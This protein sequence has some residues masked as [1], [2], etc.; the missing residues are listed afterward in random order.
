MDM[1][2]LNDLICKFDDVQ[3]NFINSIS[4]TPWVWLVVCS[5]PAQLNQK[6]IK[7]FFGAS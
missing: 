5:S 4:W 3:I 6:L 7:L 1:L 2:K